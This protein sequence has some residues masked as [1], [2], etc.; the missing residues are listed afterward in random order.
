MRVVWT[1]RAVRSLEHAFEYIATDN[2]VAALELLNRIRQIAE[3][4]GEQPYMGRAGR[5]P[6]TRELVV[7]RTAFI[8]SYQIYD[9]H[10]EILAVIHTARRWPE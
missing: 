9:T 2:P 7:S 6:D 8:V 1:Q 4:L 10:I 5:H 3:M